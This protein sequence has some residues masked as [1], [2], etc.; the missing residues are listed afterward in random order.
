MLSLPLRDASFRQG[1]HLWAGARLARRAGV[2]A[3]DS[4]GRARSALRIAQRPRGNRKK[5]RKE[6]LEAAAVLSRLSL[7]RHLR[8]AY[9]MCPRA[10]ARLRAM[11]EAGSENIRKFWKDGA[12]LDWDRAGTVSLLTH[13]LHY[14]LGAFEGIRAYRRKGGRER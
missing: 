1:R 5:M 14:G 8:G 11:V 10:A 2:P 7:F 4:R 12:I 9:R 6:R 3:S 13:T